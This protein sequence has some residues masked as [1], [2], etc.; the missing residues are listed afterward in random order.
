MLPSSVRLATAM[1]AVAAMTLAPVRLSGT[2]YPAITFDEL[3][4]QA[5]VIFVGDV[6][7]VRPFVDASPEGPVIRTRVT[8]VVRDAL[9][10]TAS[11]LEILE[12]FG[13]EIGDIG[14]RIAEMP[15]FKPGERRLVFASRV[16]GINPI[17]GF[18][19]G[20]MRLTQDASGASVVETASGHALT[21]TE[22][23]GRPRARGAGP[24]RGMTF[25]ALR[26]RIVDRLR[27]RRR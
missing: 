2:S 25:S 23:S 12:F 15:A 13:G 20:L 7:D 1:L 24:A 27:E 14:M 9:W 19:Q 11:T 16:R 21:S 4:S 26:V 18:T 3:V 22:E 10:G 8:F 5:D 17:V 6:P